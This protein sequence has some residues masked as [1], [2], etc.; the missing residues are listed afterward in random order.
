MFTTNTNS[1]TQTTA[2]ANENTPINEGANNFFYGEVSLPATTASAA[3]AT[4][5]ID[6][7]LNIALSPGMNV[8]VGLGTT[9]AAGWSVASIAGVY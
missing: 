9:V 8:Y 6:Y 2:L 3:A 5:D 7:P 4:A 1:F